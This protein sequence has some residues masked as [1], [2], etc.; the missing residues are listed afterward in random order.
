MLKFKGK[1]EA[2]IGDK[3]VGFTWNMATLCM[4]G[5]L[6]NANMVQMGRLLISPKFSTIQHFL[7]AGAV[8]RCQIENK[9]IDFTED[10]AAQWIDELGILKCI[11]LINNSFEVPTDPNPIEEKNLTAQE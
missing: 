3:T 4:L 6:Q 2:K 5:D 8:K 10:D 11:E 1:A 7:Y 9:K